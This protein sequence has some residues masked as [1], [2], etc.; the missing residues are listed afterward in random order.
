M[1]AARGRVAFVLLAPGLTMLTLF[2]LVP[3]GLIVVISVFTYSPTQLWLPPV[4]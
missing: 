3:L 4:V 2:L 1:T